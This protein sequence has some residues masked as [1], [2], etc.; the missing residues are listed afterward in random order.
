MKLKL[1]TGAVI[2][3]ALMG[4]AYATEVSCVEV[5]L[6]S[7]GGAEDLKLAGARIK[8]GKTLICQYG[9]SNNLGATTVLESGT[10]IKSTGANWNKG[11]CKVTNND[12]ST[13]SVDL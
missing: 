4:N 9:G 7:S 6:A 5:S 13:C 12:P 8:D 3:L 2:C 10:Q 11:D 1:V